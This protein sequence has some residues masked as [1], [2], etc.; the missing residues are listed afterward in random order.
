VDAARGL[1]IFL[2]L[3][4]LLYGG[5][6]AWTQRAT[7][8]AVSAAPAASAQE[9]SL[10]GSISAVGRASITVTSV[11]PGQEGEDVVLSVGPQT[12]I[13]FYQ[14]SGQGL[15]RTPASLKELKPGMQVSV[16]YAGETAE[17]IGVLPQ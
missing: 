2:V 1:L 15:T 11:N 9:H 3:S 12:N 5:Y 16:L 8:P 13:F 4:A 6:S 17:S 7:Q 14:D 10:G